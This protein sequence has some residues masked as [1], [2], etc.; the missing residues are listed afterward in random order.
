MSPEGSQ[1]GHKFVLTEMIPMDLSKI[2]EQWKPLVGKQARRAGN[3]QTG[4]GKGSRESSEPLAGP[5]GAPGELERDW[6]QGMEGQDTGNGFPLG[7]ERFKWDFGKEFLAGRVGRGWDGIPRF[8]VAAPGSLAVPKARLEHL[9]Q[10][11]VSLPMAPT[12]L[13]Q[14]WFWQ[15]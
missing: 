14:V 1:E 2:P 6:G 9:G 3:V 7:K 15:L 11:E 13:M 4:E 5:K 8:A 10:W 12:E